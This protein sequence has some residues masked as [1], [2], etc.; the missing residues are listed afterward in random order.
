[1]DLRCEVL[2]KYAEL[3]EKTDSEITQ[4]DESK[5]EWEKNITKKI[6]VDAEKIAKFIVIKPEHPLHLFSLVD[7]V[8]RL[9]LTDIRNTPQLRNSSRNSIFIN[10]VIR[11][12]IWNQFEY[13]V[14]R[15]KFIE[16]VSSLS[17]MR[18][19]VSG[20][21]SVNDLES[22][23]IEEIYESLEPKLIKLIQEKPDSDFRA[24]VDIFHWYIVNMEG[25]S[26]THEVMMDAIYTG[27]VGHNNE[28]NLQTWTISDI[29]ILI[30]SLA[31]KQQTF[32][33][34]NKSKELII[35]N[36]ISL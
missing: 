36:N 16:S 5:D 10:S 34:M 14:W 13:Y 18:I 6:T 35:L 17:L 30:Y 11:S 22:I 3:F 26:H 7:S 8:T 9:N 15:T 21:N 2:E 28:N 25:S 31:W 32:T 27:L 1:M 20:F 33:D 4:L 29:V 23:S 24:L 12:K 19:L